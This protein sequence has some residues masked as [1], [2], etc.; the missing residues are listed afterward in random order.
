MS[1]CAPNIKKQDGS[2]F[3]LDYLQILAENYNKLYNDK[4]NIINDKKQLLKN[5]T[6]KMRNRY[7]CMEQ[8]C[9]LK[10][11]VVNTIKESDIKNDIKKYTFRPDGPK[12]QFEWLSTR[13]IDKVMSQYERKYN[14]FIFLGALPNDFEDLPFLGIQDI[15]LSEVK[16]E[17]PIIGAVINL[18]I[19]TQSGS[20]WVALYAHLDENKIYY[21]DS[22]GKKPG[23]RI[24]NFS[25][26]LLK[27][28]H[29]NNTNGN[30]NTKDFLKKYKSSHMYDIRYNK[31]QHQ[32]KNSECGVYS[33][34]FLIRLLNGEDFDSIV[35]NIT[36]DDD[37]NK[38]RNIYF[39]NVNI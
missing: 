4:I 38:C 12:K 23:K 36:N 11:D 39:Q 13:D 2:C 16:K 21:F 19:H 30:F 33:M 24:R 9:W 35:D 32:F 7:N 34:N 8:S 15:N 25:N 18:D 6:N 20:H 14:K 26:K 29:S 31:T 1:K 17:T 3:T 37:M 22:F 27:F 10:T 28:M 5:L